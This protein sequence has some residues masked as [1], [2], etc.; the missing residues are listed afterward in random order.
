MILLLDNHDSFTYNLFH[1]IEELGHRVQ[2]SSS[3]EIGLEEIEQLAPQALIFSAGPC[4]P[5]EAGIT[6]EAAQTFFGK[7]PLLGVC[8]GHQALGMA[9]GVDLIRSQ[10]PVHGTA[11]P[12][13][14]D[15]D[16][17]LF[18]GLPNPLFAA[19]YNSLVLADCPEGYQVTARSS[20]GEIMAI[21]HPEARAFGLQFHP[22]SFMTREG[23]QI[24]RNFFHA[25]QRL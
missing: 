15:P 25:A 6:L 2:I 24:M 1:L 21:E 23:Y 13:E 11:V 16:S 8:L 9:A 14:V 5:K 17:C 10:D 4:T 7:I 18:K 19:R 3:R 12:L 22:E 20:K